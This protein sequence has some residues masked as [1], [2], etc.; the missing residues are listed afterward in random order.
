MTM[1]ALS[2]AASAGAA[3]MHAIDLIAQNVANAG[4]TGYKRARMTF[5]DLVDGQLGMGMRAATVERQFAA[6]TLRATSRELDLAVE[7]EGFLRVR[8]PD[9]SAA[10]TRAGDLRRDAEGRVVTAD[11]LPLEPELVVPEGVT[12]IVVDPA[13]GVQ[14]FDPDAGAFVEIGQVGLSR[15]AN[16]AGLQPAGANLF[17]ETATAGERTDGLPGQDEGFGW[18][19]QGHLEQSNVDLVRE[20]GDLAAAQRA[21]EINSR[22]IDAAD[23]VLRAISRLGERP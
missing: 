17:V 12:R 1:R 9:G 7:G 18:I 4:T 2:I 3:Y 21:F 16:P 20:M 19:R 5:A 6:G 8:R 11:G 15:F 22:V 13:G 14:G 10:Y 23:Q